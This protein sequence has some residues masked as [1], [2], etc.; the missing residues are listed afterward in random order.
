MSARKLSM[1]ELNRISP[2]EFRLAGKLPV[3][4][5]LDNIRSQN[6]TGSAFRTS[7]AF[8]IERICLCGITAVPPHREIHKTALGAEDTVEWKYYKS[9]LDAIREL[10]TSGYK[11]L[12]I[13]QTD[14]GLPVQQFEPG[15]NLKFAL[16][17]GNEINGVDEEILAY[18]DS[19]L[20]IPQ[21][22]TKHSL[23]VSVVIGII[24]WEV[25]RK[26]KKI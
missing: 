2:E 9:T 15:E 24:L 21:F 4:V 23:N 14:L 12:V 1:K 6:N 19:C 26:I 17:F 8:R 3:T 7:D 11:I 20:D 5:V 10:K 16:V 18:A 22:G 13:E 25:L